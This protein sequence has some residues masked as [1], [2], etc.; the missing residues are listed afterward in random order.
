MESFEQFAA[1]DLEADGFVVSSAIK[2]PIRRRTKRASYVEYQSHGYEVDLIGA[3][4]DRLVLATV[5]SYFGSTGV[6]S[7]EVRGTGGGVSRYALINDRNL[8]NR[9]VEAAAE[10][11]GYRTNQVRLRM[12]VGKFAG[13]TKGAQEAEIRSWCASKIAGGGPIE[14]RSAKQIAHRVREIA[15]STT[16]RDNPGLVTMKVLKQAGF[17]TEDVDIAE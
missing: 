17:L 13:Q 12:Y 7:R 4:R 2:F 6:Q 1:L 10:R 5:K 15:A 8:R 9:I 16:Y 14:V 3:R 11:Y